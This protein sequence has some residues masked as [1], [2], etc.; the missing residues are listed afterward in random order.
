MKIWNLKCTFVQV[1]FI[2]LLMITSLLPRQMLTRLF[3]CQYSRG[4]SQIISWSCR[5]LRINYA[6]EHFRRI[7]VVDNWLFALQSQFIFISNYCFRIYYYGTAH[8]LLK[9]WL[10]ENKAYDILHNVLPLT[11]KIQ[12]FLFSEWYY[13]RSHKLLAYFFLDYINRK[14]IKIYATKIT[15]AHIVRSSFVISRSARSKCDILK[16]ISYQKP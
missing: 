10:M 11:F 2:G 16:L 14:S 7:S 13:T 8:R 4:S 3:H 5:L 15:L 1:F 9:L 12:F 6:I